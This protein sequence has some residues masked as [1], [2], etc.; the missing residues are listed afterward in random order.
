[1]LYGLLCDAEDKIVSSVTSVSVHDWLLLSLLGVIGL[2]GFLFLVRALLLIPPTTVAVLRASEIVLAYG[3]QAIVVGQVER[4]CFFNQCMYCLQVPDTFALLGSS[5][6]M[7]SVS[8]IAMENS[9][10]ILST[11]LWKAWSSLNVS[12]GKVFGQSLPF[13]DKSILQST[14]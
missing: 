12:C 3:I 13:K 6:V 2:V 1:M 14:V 7:A 4:A 9:L 10:V 8:A 5:L 11:H